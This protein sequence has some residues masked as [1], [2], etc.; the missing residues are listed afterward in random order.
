MI[1]YL[2]LIAALFMCFQNSY[3]QANCAGALTLTPGV[4]QCGDSAGQPGDFPADGSAPTNI[5]NS[6]YNDDE[7]WFSY[8]P[9]VADES[10]DLTLSNISMTW[11]GLFVA[12][13]CPSG[14]PTCI[15]SATNSSG[16]GDIS[17]NSGALNLGTTYYIYISNYGA[18]NN[19]GFCL[20]ATIVPPAAPLDYCGTDQ[21]MDNG[22]AAGDYAS[23]SNDSWT[24]CPDVPTDKVSISFA[25][26]AVEDNGSG[27]C[28]DELK[29]YDGDD[30]TAPQ[31]GPAAGFCYDGIG[32]N[33][34]GY[35][36]G[37]LGVPIVSSH[38]SG[39]LH[40]EFTSDGSVT[41]AGW[42]ADV[43]CAPYSDPAT[44]VALAPVGTTTMTSDNAVQGTGGYTYYED[45]NNAGN[46]LFAV[47]WDAAGGGLNDASDVTI[48]VDNAASDGTADD[49]TYATWTMKRYWNVDMGTGNLADPVDVKFF[50]DAA[51]KT[52]TEMLAA[53][54]GRPL[55]L[56]AWFKTPAGTPW[57]NVPAAGNPVVD[58]IELVDANAGAGTMEN[59]VVYA[60]FAAVPSFSG[61]TFASGVG[62]AG[63][64]SLPVELSAFS[65]KSMDKGNKLIWTTASEDNASHYEIQRRN[66]DVNRWESLGEVQAFGNSNV[67]VDYEFMDETPKTSNFYRLK[68]IDL[69]GQFEYSNIIIIERKESNIQNAT[70]YPNPTNGNIVV[71]QIS[72]NATT[73]SLIIYNVQGQMVYVQNNLEIEAG[74]S[75]IPLDIEDLNSGV[76]MLHLNSNTNSQVIKFIK[77]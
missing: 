41:R 35:P 70:I 46:Y 4:Q 36:G 48:T 5:C 22:G 30:N 65:G 17:L 27:T 31:I 72:T 2:L 23:S 37:G 3:S 28:Y 69:D 8:S 42:I 51:E 32:T 1:K 38:S 45:P 40:F 54:D 58:A 39:C 14:T 62:I 33:G 52:A 10:L 67:T 15:T 25:E 47:N 56:P 74:V 66:F 34:T 57:A 44:T 73:L 60:E 49:G 71:E 59:G 29:I 53:S 61:G 9:A 50:Y 55:E 18:P 75:K 20:D 13:D 68:M 76:Y 63:A 77:N 43:T 19:T 6:N 64:S 11:A 7:Y 12:D 24:I 16:T 26:F 21:F